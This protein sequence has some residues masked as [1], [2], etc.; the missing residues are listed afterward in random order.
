LLTCQQTS[1]FGSAG[2][3]FWYRSIHIQITYTYLTYISHFLE[4]E[5]ATPEGKIKI[6]KPRQIGFKSYPMVS[7]IL[8]SCT[9]HSV[10]IFWSKDDKHVIW[11]WIWLI[12]KNISLLDRIWSLWL[13][14]FALLTCQQTSPF[15]VFESF[16]HPFIPCFCYF[17]RKKNY[18][19][20]TKFQK[21]WN[22]GQI[23][24]CYLD[25]NWSIPK[26]SLLSQ[27]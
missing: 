14:H 27:C 9:F 23:S 13:V 25:V 15:T 24:I 17:L 5:S 19:P 16:S 8:R 21:M 3:Y 1:Y 20:L 4:F 11:M 12:L 6:V 10:W 18:L 7:Q 26:I 22:V 2:W